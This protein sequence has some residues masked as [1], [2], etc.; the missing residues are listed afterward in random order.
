MT[1]NKCSI[2]RKI[3]GYLYDEADNEIEITDV[4][5]KFY[6]KLNSTSLV[7]LFSAF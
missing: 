3:Y 4:G 5:R 2:N 7:I 1:F 6:F